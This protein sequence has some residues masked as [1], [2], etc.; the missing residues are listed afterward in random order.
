MAKNLKQESDTNENDE[1]QGKK[2][3]TQNDIV[4]FLKT[5]RR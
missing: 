3:E 2:G 4:N 5:H 1:M